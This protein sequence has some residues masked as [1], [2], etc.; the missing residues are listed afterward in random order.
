M[1]IGRRIREA[2]EKLGWTQKDLAGKIGV[3]SSSIANYEA[4]TSHPKEPVL[5]ALIEALQVDA[6]FLFQDCV[7]IKEFLFTPDE[8]SLIENYR[9]L[10]RYDQETIRTL[11]QREH[12]RYEAVGLY[13]SI[14]DNC[15]TLRLSD[16]P[17]SAGK[18]VYLGPEAFTDIKVRKRPETCDADFVIRVSG[19]SMEPK[20]HDGDYLLIK[21]GEVSIGDIALVTLDGEGYIK[22]IGDGVLTSLNNHYKPIPLNDSV[23][24][25]GRVIGV[26]K[27]EWILG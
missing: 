2:R 17:A 10:S 23:R 19:D 8:K 7:K 22:R 24:V 1:G 6:N 9:K 13:H 18:G 20:Y 27:P 4:E 16:Q 5:Y 21:T 25:N 14:G 26:L 15:I 11:I 3:T 12:G